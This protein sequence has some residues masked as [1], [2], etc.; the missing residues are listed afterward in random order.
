MKKYYTEEELWGW[1]ESEL[2]EL[3]LNLQ[4]ANKPKPRK[5]K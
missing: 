3:I 2:I 4:E 1:G 5:K